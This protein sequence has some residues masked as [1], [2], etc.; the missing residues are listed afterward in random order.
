MTTVI[1]KEW[2]NYKDEM[3]VI[4]SKYKSMADAFWDTWPT[5]LETDCQL[6]NDII[7]IENIAQKERYQRVIKMV[8]LCEYKIFHGLLIGATAYG[9][10]GTEFWA[11]KSGGTKEETNTVRDS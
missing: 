3:S 1:E 4:K 8:S 7:T 9:I 11:N 5:D 6:I 10:K 2:K